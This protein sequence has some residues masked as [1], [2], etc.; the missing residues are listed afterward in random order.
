MVIQVNGKVRARLDVNPDI[1]EDDAA[2][3]ALAHS[4]V[5]TILD[6]ASPQRVVSR[7]PRLVNI[8]L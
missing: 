5:H 2:A 7:P 1:T 4:D 6:G 3:A 8:I